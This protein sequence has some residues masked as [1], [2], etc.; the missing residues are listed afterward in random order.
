MKK[1]SV[2]IVHVPILRMEH[3]KA[4]KILDR[5][6]KKF[7]KVI[8]RKDV[9]VVAVPSQAGNYEFESVLLDR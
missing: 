2:V 9:G 7:K 6:V 4:K 3:K 5:C 1:K 8:N